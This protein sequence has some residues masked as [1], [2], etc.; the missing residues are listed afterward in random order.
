[1]IDEFSLPN[2]KIHNIVHDNASNMTNAIK[3]L[4]DFN[5]LPCFTHTT[6]LVV[7]NAVLQQPSVQSLMKKCKAIGNYLSHSTKAYHLLEQLQREMNRT[8]LKFINEVCTRWD[9]EYES[10]KRVKEMKIE[11]LVFLAQV[12][13]KLGVT[14]TNS[15]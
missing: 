9:S 3:V 8:V 4:S 7:D 5:S 12:H 10:L 11:L 6:Q 14:L 13:G 2:Y 15:D 1:M